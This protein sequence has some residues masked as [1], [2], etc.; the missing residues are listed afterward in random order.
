MDV[1]TNLGNVR[2]GLNNETSSLD[3]AKDAELK[4]S[5]LS[6]P[7]ENLGPAETLNAGPVQ[8][9]DPQLVKPIN[10]SSEEASRSIKKVEDFLNGAQEGVL[11]VDDEGIIL[12][13]NES[14]NR[15]VG[16]TK[17]D[18]IGRDYKDV[19]DESK[20]IAK[21]LEEAHM[22]TLKFLAESEK[23]RKDLDEKLKKSQSIFIN[24]I[25]TFQKILESRDQYMQGHSARVARYSMMLAKRMGLDKD[26]VQNMA[27]AGIFHDLGMVNIPMDI[28][29]K[30]TKLTPSEYM[31]IMKHPVISVEYLEDIDIFKDILPC[32]KYHHERWDGNGYPE[33]LAGEK[34]PIEARVLFVAEAFDAL[35]S[36]RPYRLA[37]DRNVAAKIL[38][39]NKE[40]QFDPKCVDNFIYLVQNKII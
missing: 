26:A 35:T 2:H 17:N 13:V 6:E 5:E 29:H 20:D 21:S 11:A 34:I 16:K 1:S 9:N 18:I 7:V 31:V 15:V 22:Q 24:M 38:I 3:A 37:R 33:R 23:N 32:I 40:T 19:F 8:N 39:D 28:V 14:L 25:V 10:I 27:Y 36:R 4:S 12:Y 30:A